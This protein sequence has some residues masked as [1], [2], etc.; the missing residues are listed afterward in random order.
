MALGVCCEL[1]GG[2]TGLFQPQGDG[3]KALVY[4]GLYN[5]NVT[6]ATNKTHKTCPDS[7]VLA[8]EERKKE[9]AWLVSSYD[10]HKGKLWLNSDLPNP[11]GTQSKII[12]V[13]KYASL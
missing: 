5:G 9:Y 3:W 13:I 12:L 10:T 8:G 1:Q 6:A 4:C 2:A 11:Q 7:V